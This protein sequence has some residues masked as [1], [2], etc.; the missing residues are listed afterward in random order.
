[1][2]LCLAI[3][4]DE[5][6]CIYRTDCRSLVCDDAGRDDDRTL[7]SCLN[8]LNMV[9]W[10][11]ATCHS[12]VHATDFESFF[13]VMLPIGQSYCSC[14]PHP[15]AFASNLLATRFRHLK[16]TRNRYWKKYRFSNKHRNFKEE[17]M[18]ELNHTFSSDGCLCGISTRSTLLLSTVLM[19]LHTA[20]HFGRSISI[21]KIY[22]IMYVLDSLQ[23]MGVREILLIFFL[24]YELYFRQKKKQQK[25]K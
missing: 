22:K 15:I 16:V 18:C 24:S 11:Y 21:I 9:G 7:Q 3:E 19:R 23:W 25:H 4:C 5:H 20:Q 13:P 8:H 10:S 6:F 1:M 14:W 17:K 12:L 2:G